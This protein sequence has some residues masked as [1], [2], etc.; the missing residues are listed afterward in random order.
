[1]PG[2]ASGDG[3]G[4]EDIPETPEDQ[5]LTQR[6]IFDSLTG[7]GTPT[8][9]FEGDTDYGVLFYQMERMDLEDRSDYQSELPGPKMKAA[10]DGDFDGGDIEEVINQQPDGKGVRALRDMVAEALQHNE[11]TDEEIA[12]QVD[13]FGEEQL[14]RAVKKLNNFSAETAGITGFRSG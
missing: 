14:G 9:E 10:K 4:N 8:T 6:E 5:E 13:K 3:D 12:V 7:G 1:M 2:D 11:F